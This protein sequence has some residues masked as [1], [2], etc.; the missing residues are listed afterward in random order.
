MEGYAKVA[1]LMGMHPE[2]GILRRFQAL[3]MQNL[4]YLQAE[5]THLEAELHSIAKEDIASGKMP[6]HT[7][8]WWTLS[9][10]HEFGDAKQ[11]QMALEIREK[12]EKYSTHQMLASFDDGSMTNINFRRCFAKASCDI[13]APLPKEA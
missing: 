10:G 12:L 6:G 9:Q 2:F 13:E 3:N 1:S 5:I 4:L 8:D 7:H 11:W